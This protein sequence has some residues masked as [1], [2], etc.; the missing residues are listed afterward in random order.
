MKAF[1]DRYGFNVK[2]VSIQGRVNE[3]ISDHF[4]DV[5][6][7]NGMAEAF[8]IEQA[9]ALM[10]YDAQ[11]QNVVPVTYGATSMDVLKNNFVTLLKG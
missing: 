9:P 1:A 4:P 10:A 3:D 7:N 5:V 6:M 11:N 8:G 2:V